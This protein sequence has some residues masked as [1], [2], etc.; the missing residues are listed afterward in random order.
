MPEPLGLESKTTDAEEGR[1]LER[2]GAHD[3]RQY[4]GFPQRFVELERH[5]LKD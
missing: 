1:R 3:R 2:D 4:S 5:A